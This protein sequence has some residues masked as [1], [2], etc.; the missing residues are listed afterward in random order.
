MTKGS[1]QRDTD[2]SWRRE[3]FIQEFDS[4]LQ[5]LSLGAGSK[6]VSPGGYS[7]SPLKVRAWREAMV[8]V[9]Q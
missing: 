9:R 3:V 4:T 8:V 5:T 7:D 2:D 6:G 1:L